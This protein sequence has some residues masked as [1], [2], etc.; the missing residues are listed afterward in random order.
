MDLRRLPV[1]AGPVLAGLLV[2]GGCA[3]APDAAA[4]TATAA[5]AAAA[6]ASGGQAP[7]T[8]RMRPGAGNTGGLT[9][10]PEAREEIARLQQGG[11]AGSAPD[12]A[13]AA[14][15]ADAA[16]RVGRATRPCADR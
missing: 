5:P 10:T 4:P 11:Q 7:C 14:R 13:L 1:L 6:P 15:L 9:L 12:P 16:D 3:G 8:T 2:L